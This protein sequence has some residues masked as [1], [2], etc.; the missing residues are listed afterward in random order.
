MTRNE[1]DILDLLLS[2]GL[3]ALAFYYAPQMIR[4]FEAGVNAL[5]DE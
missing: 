2:L 1:R 4:F 3:L 5:L